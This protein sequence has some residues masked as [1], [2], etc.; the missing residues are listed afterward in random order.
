MKKYLL[1]LTLSVTYL[2]LWLLSGVP[3]SAAKSTV[4]TTSAS[5]SADSVPTQGSIS[6]L[7]Q[8]LKNLK[9]RIAS[10]VAEMKL[11]E[12]KGIIGN[13]TD[14]SETQLT[15]TDRNG[16]DRLVDVDELTHF[17]SPSAKPGFG[18]SDLTRGTTVSA[19]GIYNKDSR[20]ILARFVDVFKPVNAISGVVSALDSDNY[21]ITVTTSEQKDILVDIENITKTYVYDKTNG[22][23]KSGFSKIKPNERIMTIGTWDSNNPNKLIA[24]R[25]LR[26]P[27]IPVNPKILLFKPGE[28]NANITPSTGSGMKL[29]PIRK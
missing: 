1:I 20:R 18:L 15:L 23:T 14:I 7:D 16:N 22:L 11:V 2:P 8:Q 26:F 6:E 9:E 29:T 4:I 5:S 24:T 12:K 13:V 27:T 10:K 21:T 25:I 28:L 3:A 17:S 19:L